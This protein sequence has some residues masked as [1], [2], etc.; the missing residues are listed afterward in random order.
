VKKWKKRRGAT[1]KVEIP[2][3]ALVL[4]PV[5]RIIVVCS[6]VVDVEGPSH[7]GGTVSSCDKCGISVI[8]PPS[9]AVTL[10]WC[11]P[12]AARTMTSGTTIYLRTEQEKV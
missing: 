7:V 11:V 1:V 8:A 4:R 9:Q 5:E 10:H 6:R 2:S 12:C 3:Q